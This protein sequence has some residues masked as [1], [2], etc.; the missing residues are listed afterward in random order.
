MSDK[1]T[2]PEPRASRLRSELRS[3]GHEAVRRS[4]ARDQA[5]AEAETRRRRQIKSGDDDPLDFFDNVPL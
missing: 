4:A 1:R 5:V 3:L 2:E